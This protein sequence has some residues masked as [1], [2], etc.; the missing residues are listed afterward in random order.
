MDAENQILGRLA[1]K[2][3]GLL[4]GKNKP[5]FI[6]NKDEGDFVVVKNA[7]KVKFTGKKA[8]Q[9]KYFRHSLYMGGQTIT[10]L[11]ELLKKKPNE[12]LKLAVMGMLP[13]NRLRAQRIKRLKFL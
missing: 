10:T 9:K 4:M 3:A 13:K 5:S 8:E 7:G 2:I 11:G 12:A 6:P 1:V